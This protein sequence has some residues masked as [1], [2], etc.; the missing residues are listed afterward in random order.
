[1][2]RRVVALAA[3]VLVL[4]SGV[5]AAAAAGDGVRAAQLDVEQPAWVSDPVRTMDA[6]NGSVYV[7]KGNEFEISVL[8]VD[9]EN[10]VRSGV[11]ESTGRLTYDS[12]D[13]EYVFSPRSTNG[14]FTLYWVVEREV[15]SPGN[16][17][18]GNATGNATTAGDSV[19]VTR[20]YTAQV[21]VEHADFTHEPAAQDAAEERK[22]GYWDRVQSMIG[23]IPGVESSADTV[24]KTIEDTA[25]PW[26]RFTY[27]PTSQIGGTLVALVS[28]LIM[29]PGG[30]LWLSIWLG[31]TL[32]VVG[33]ALKYRQSARDDLPGAED[34]EREKQEMWARIRR[35]ELKNADFVDDLGL[36]E[37]W[38]SGFRSEVGDN[39]YQVLEA[40]LRTIKPGELRAMAAV[41]QQQHHDSADYRVVA[42][43]ES[44]PTAADII[45]VTASDAAP[46]EWAASWTPSETPM[47]AYE[48][49]S[50][51]A[52]ESWDALSA[53]VDLTAVPTDIVAQSGDADDVITRLGIDLRRGFEESP[54]DFAQALSAFLEGA[55]SH[56]HVVD[57]GESRQ[58]DLVAGLYAVVETADE[59]YEVPYVQYAKDALVAVAEGL[60]ASVGTRRYIEESRAEGVSDPLASSHD[61][62]DALPDGGDSAD[63]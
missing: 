39:P 59:R 41:A 47:T 55:A 30:W 36:S 8:N 57:G 60:D 45:D 52:I 15:P 27:N 28:I 56:E 22:A 25:V 19:T 13:D 7:V 29:R 58:R 44:D 62:G 9:R 37:R 42:D 18:A 40:L 43:S 3:V 1:M 32:V 26:I 38:A 53:G 33:G 2:T 17:T 35:R 6:Q 24:L 4:V 34:V 16:E 20:T 61:D 54:E 63:D 49:L 50:W 10:V 5:G 51:D 14:T 31:A 21:R 23:G 46:A 48:S 12:R 11:R